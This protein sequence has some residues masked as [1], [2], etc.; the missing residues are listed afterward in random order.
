MAD[1]GVAGAGG[2]FTAEH[3]REV[4]GSACAVAGLSAEGASLLRLGENA[5]FRL[6]DPDVVRVARSA[7]RVDEHERT[8]AAA[9][10]L[11]EVGFPAVRVTSR[12][13]Q[14]LVVDGRV[15]TFWELV[16]EEERFA[17]VVALAELLR[18]LHWLEE[19]ASLGLPYLEPLAAT[20]G[21]IDAA[22][23]LGDDDR[24]FLRQRAEELRKRY[25]ALEFV[26]PFG[27]VHGDASVGNALVDEAGRAVL[28]DL[29]GFALGPREWDLVLTAMYYE[30][31]GWHTRA[32]YEAFV[33]AYGFDV[34]NWYGYPVLAD[35][36][37][38]MMTVWLTQNMAGD[39]EVAAE[40]E[41]RIS[42]LRS[43]GD[44]HG[45]KPF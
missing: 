23:A 15:V 32:E 43:G 10:W 38:L 31:Y 6:S 16:A 37:E 20:W 39:A 34:M 21:R 4:L 30:R 45:W 5:V 18:R 36:R 17:G 9:R 33:N 26:L 24:G 19:P 2:A 13:R 25:D 12:I 14:P 29:D 42:D 7:D 44:R 22:V 40:V 27:L 28:I 1:G 35:M 41:R 11:A 3:A 8:V